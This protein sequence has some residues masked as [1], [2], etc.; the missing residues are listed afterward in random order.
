MIRHLSHYRGKR[1]RPA[2]LLLTARACGEVR[3]THHVLAAVVEMIHTATLVHDDVPNNLAAD[4]FQERGN[5]EEAA[6]KADLVVKRKILV[7]NPDR[8]SEEFRDQAIFLVS[9]HGDDDEAVEIL[10]HVVRNDRSSEIRHRTGDA[11]MKRRVPLV[12][13]VWFVSLPQVRA[14]RA[15]FRPRPDVAAASSVS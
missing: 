7:E 12:P 8:Y 11:Q 1:L 15:G 14:P 4:V 3:H 9:Q 6:K 10:M 2:L 13:S 5:Y